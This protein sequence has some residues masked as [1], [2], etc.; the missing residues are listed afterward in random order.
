MSLTVSIIIRRSQSVKV[1]GS[2]FAHNH[3]T[4]VEKTH[5]LILGQWVVY[6]KVLLACGL[7]GVGNV[8]R[9]NKQNNNNAQQLVTTFDDLISDQFFSSWAAYCAPCFRI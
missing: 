6:H 2:Y 1:S 5:P 7:A 8:L 3:E 4:F 9:H